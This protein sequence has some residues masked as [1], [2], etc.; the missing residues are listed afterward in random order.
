[1]ATHKNNQFSYKLEKVYS[2]GYREEVRQILN[3]LE[4]PAE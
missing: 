1:M 3:S 4:V 2:Q